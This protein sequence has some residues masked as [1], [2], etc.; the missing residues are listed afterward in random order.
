MKNTKPPHNTS[1]IARG[2]FHLLKT[3]AMVKSYTLRL[4]T[5]APY[6]ETGN[7]KLASHL[8]LAAIW[9]SHTVAQGFW[10]AKLQGFGF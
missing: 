4:R 3:A 1:A 2:M 9:S 5:V 6:R 7:A 8:N 10:G